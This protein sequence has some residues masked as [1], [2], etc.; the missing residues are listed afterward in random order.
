MN[1]KNGLT[2]GFVA[3][4][5]LSLLMM[6]RH[7]LGIAPQLDLIAMLAGMFGK[8]TGTPPDPLIGW[9]VHFF[10]GTVLWGIAY[11]AVQAALAGSPTVRGMSFGVAA[12]LLMMA[13]VMPL[14]GAGLFGTRLGIE[15]PVLTL[16]MH[17]VFGATLGVVYVRKRITG[18]V[19]R[20]FLGLAVA[21]LVAGCAPAKTIVNQ[22]E[23]PDPGPA[24]TRVLVVG[25]IRDVSVRRTFE[26]QMVAAL[27]AR[28]V[29][30]EPAYRYAPEDG[31]LAQAAIERA[32]REAGATGVLTTRVV[33]VEQQASVVPPPA[34]GPPYG[35]Y[36]WYGSAWGPAFA[37]PYGYAPAQVVVSDNVYAEVR[38][39]RV[40]GD[41]LLW[42][43]TTQT[44][45]PSNPQ[46]DSAAFA[47]VIVAQLFMRRLI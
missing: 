14:A 1:I 10:V 44:F 33:K 45:S 4:V 13:I 34:W 2:A 17:L 40:A 21:A 47:N 32:V 28:G 6:A 15:A 26:D 24:L 5:V 8:M 27:R 19:R 35:F 7:S 9:L 12:W 36:G 43:A 16:V 31:P 22:W 3:T 20:A 29:Q 11:A 38:L 18:T 39:Y 23:A 41:A 37:Y 25:V 46:Q 42:A 30:A